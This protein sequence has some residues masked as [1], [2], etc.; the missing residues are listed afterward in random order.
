MK[1]MMDWVNKFAGI[2]TASLSLV[3]GAG[4]VAASLCCALPLPLSAAGF[5]GAWLRGFGELE[6]YR[7]HVLAAAAIAVVLGWTAALRRGRDACAPDG[8]CARPA[9]SWMSFA[10]LSLSTLMVGIAAA[11]DWSEPTAMTAL[12]RLTAGAA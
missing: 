9:R 2:G 4:A 8:A 6:A 7:L 5:G 1:N 3:T 10:V 11:W 12:M